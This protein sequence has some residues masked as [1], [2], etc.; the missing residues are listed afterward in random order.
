MQM[1]PEEAIEKYYM[2]RRL[3]NKYKSSSPVMMAE[4]WEHMFAE[5]FE[6]LPQV[7]WLGIPLTLLAPFKAIAFLIS[8]DA[9]PDF[10]LIAKRAFED[11][12]SQ[13]TDGSSTPKQ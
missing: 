2:C 4:T 5:W 3:F 8:A 6:N 13:D 9:K 7:V 12:M 11:K 1:S 10:E